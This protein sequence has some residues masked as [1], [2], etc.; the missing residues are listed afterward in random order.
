MKA[1]KYLPIF[2]FLILT[3]LPLLAGVGYA[4]GQS[5]GLIGIKAKGWSLIY[6]ERAFREPEW[7][8]S[9]AYSGA[10]SLV[11]VGLALLMALFSCLGLKKYHQSAWRLL[12]YLPL[13]VPTIVAAFFTFQL[14]SGGGWVARVAFALGLISGPENFPELVQDPW[15]VGI[16][17]SHLM[18]AFPFFTLL[19]MN[20]YQSEKIDQLS[21]LAATLGA[22]SGQRILRVE[23]PLLLKGAYP[24]ILMYLIFIIGS[25]EI[26]LL[27]GRQS[28][29]MISI[30]TLDKLQSYDLGARPLA[31]VYALMY[32][33]FVLILLLVLGRRRPAN[34]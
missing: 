7:L 6:W 28:P 11:S 2:L 15:S 21:Q 10:I 22:N 24:V 23:I 25:Y 29:R 16:I 30:L 4:L 1:P 27:L 9:L 20:I 33:F 18:L 34:V 31:Y 17:L 19:L 12:F 8:Y 5:L 13:A 32:A 26:P 14:L 3:V